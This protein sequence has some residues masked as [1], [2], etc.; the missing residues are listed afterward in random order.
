MDHLYKYLLVVLLFTFGVSN[1]SSYAQN[2]ADKD[3]YLVDSLDIT[4]LSESDIVLLDTNLTAF[5]QEK[6]DTSKI[7]F[8]STIVEESWDDNVWPKYNQW[9]YSYTKKLLKKHLSPV[10]KR[11]VFLQHASAINNIGYLNS[12]KGN[13]PQALKLYQQSLAIEE[14]YND[15]ENIPTSLN[16]IATIYSKLGKIPEAL[17]IYHKSLL[18]YKKYKNKQGIAQTLNNIGHIYDGQGESDLALEYFHKSLKIYEL[19]ENNRGV[20]TLL[21]GIGYIYFKKENI[22]KA[23]AYYNK[24]IAIRIKMNDQIG[25]ATTLNNIASVYENQYANKKAMEYYNKCLKIYTTNNHKEGLTTTLNNI[26]RLYLIL[27]DVQ[28]AKENSTLSLQLAKEAKN[29][30]NIKFSAYTLSTIYEAEGN[31][32]E[33]LKMYKLYVSM[34]DSMNNERTQSSTAKLQAKYEYEN[35][36]A[37][38]DAENDKVLAIK[39]GEKKQQTIISIAT[40]TGLFFVIIFLLFIS[41]R[42]KVT[43]KQKVI[44]EKQ[45]KEIIDSITYAKRIQ[46]AILPTDKW[47]KE[48]LPNSFIYYQPKDIVAGDFYWVESVL[49]GENRVMSDAKQSSTHNTQN[50]PLILFAA[51]DCTGHGVPGALMSVVC[52]NAMNRVIGEFNIVD[53]AEILTKTRE[54]IIDQLSK[55]DNNNVESIG[56]IRDGMDIALCAYNPINKQ[57][58]YAGANNPLWILRKGSSEMEEI[59]ATKQS[60]SNVDVRKPYLNHAVQLNTGDTVY[61]FSDGYADQFGG[62]KGKKF[63]SKPF[64]E[65]LI[66][67]AEK[68]MTEQ[69][70]KLQ[71]FFNEWRGDLEQI[72]DVCVMGFRV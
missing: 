57:L 36:K 69:K 51:A 27:G 47:V 53:P 25:I 41:N 63:K 30:S 6:I 37:I 40:G 72:D 42:L 68:P 48:N 56:K 59:K 20:A 39:E 44:I 13:L 52:H 18:Q 16:N 28:H 9:I 38:D 34:K 19:L 50:I 62:K 32:K 24:A 21:N 14:E 55:A 2:F 4:S 22:D 17:E 61:I 5:H 67:N 65:L 12:T 66:S 23:L 58:N 10:V 43:Q 7:K 29:P 11:R 45:N 54:I 31:E 46:D 49:S 1:Q 35:N 60:V 71:H 15:Q 64:K 8:I 70:D 26:G 3:Y 33:A